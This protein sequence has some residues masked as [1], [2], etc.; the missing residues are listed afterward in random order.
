MDIPTNF[1]MIMEV[2]FDSARILFRKYP[3]HI[4]EKNSLI[5]YYNYCLRKKLLAVISSII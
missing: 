3:C 4:P 5:E 1:S 2:Q